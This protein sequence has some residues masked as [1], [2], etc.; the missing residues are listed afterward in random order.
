MKRFLKLSLSIEYSGTHCLVLYN[1][2]AGYKNILSTL[3]T[4][5]LLSHNPSSR[6]HKISLIY[7]RSLW[8]F[9][10]RHFMELKPYICFL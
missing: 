6:P 8:I 3:E 1:T 5:K 4:L 7:V 9:Y 2:T 10:L